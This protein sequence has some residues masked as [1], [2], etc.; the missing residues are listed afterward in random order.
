MQMMMSAKLMGPWRQTWG[1]D[2]SPQF[3]NISGKK[4][5]IYIE[6]EEEERKSE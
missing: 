1:R 2:Y 4:M 5:Y 6:R 3:S